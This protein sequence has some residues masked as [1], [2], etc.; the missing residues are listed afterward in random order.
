MTTRSMNLSSAGR[1]RLENV[2]SDVTYTAGYQKL[3]DDQDIVLETVDSDG[4]VRRYQHRGISG[5]GAVN[6][7]SEK[8]VMMGVANLRELQA[9]LYRLSDSQVPIETP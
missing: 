2:M 7:L 8:A 1:A 5:I 3:Y 4:L 6:G 9:F